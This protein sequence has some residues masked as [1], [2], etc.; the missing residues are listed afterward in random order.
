MRSALLVI[1][2]VFTSATWSCPVF[3]KTIDLRRMTEASGEYQISFCARPSPGASGLPGH[4]FV[5]FSKRTPGGDWTFHSIGKTIAAGTTP[6]DAAWSYF[7]S[8]VS[9]LLKPE[10]HTSALQTCLTASVSSKD[11]HAAEALAENPLAR[12]GLGLS[13]DPVF[14][15]Y[16][17]GTE[18]C[19]SFVI[20]VASILKAAGLKAPTRHALDTP[21]EYV[22]ALIQVN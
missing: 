11:Y 8:P 9:G 22:E 16:K 4:A 10:V 12:Y 3:A 15:F 13:S 19:I 5:A 18:D 6:V 14:E 20:D 1:F 7:G 21:V 17:L 2:A